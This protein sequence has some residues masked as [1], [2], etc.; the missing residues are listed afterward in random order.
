[1]GT[2][3]TSE[4]GDPPE[5]PEPGHRRP[6]WVVGLA[7]LGLVVVLLVGAF[8]LE[9]QSRPQVG[10][11][12]PLAVTGT[13]SAQAAAGD[14]QP[15]AQSVAAP[16]ETAA[17]AVPAAVETV[18]GLHVAN[19]PLEREIEAAYLHYWDVR[20]Q[21]YSD[22]DTTHLPEVMAGA[23]L[24]RE[25]QQITDL[26][27]QGRAANIVAEHRIAFVRVSDTSAELYDEY[28]N[29]SYL[30]DATTRQ[31]IQPPGPGGT[32]KVTYQLEKADGVW[33]VIDGRRLD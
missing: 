19:S 18:G 30:I 10:V 1:M 9:S 27:N 28:L 14:V 17:A 2:D 15:T 8:L 3:E 5:N 21:A 32:A 26:K 31:A 13:T 22:L 6:Y 7:L 23:E 16:P 33:R 24:E 12:V 4:Q 29:K 25:R 20:S 11:E